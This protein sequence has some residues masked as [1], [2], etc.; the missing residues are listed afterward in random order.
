[1]KMAMNA[2][3]GKK[4]EPTVA[5]IVHEREGSFQYKGEVDLPNL[6]KAFQYKAAKYEFLWFIC[7]EC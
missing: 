6:L 2:A 1:M 3:Q 7:I 4:L 5:Y